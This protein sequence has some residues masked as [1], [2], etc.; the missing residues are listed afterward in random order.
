MAGSPGYMCPEVAVLMLEDKGH[1]AQVIELIVD[2]GVSK[3]TPAVAGAQW[4][5]EAQFKVDVYAFGVLLAALV[6]RGAPYPDALSA[7]ELLYGTAREGLRPTVPELHIGSGRHCNEGYVNGMESCWSQTPMDRP[8]FCEVRVLL[9]KAV[10][11][12]EEMA[13]ACGTVLAV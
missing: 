1:D 6:T 8:T 11:A 3:C 10:I 2:Q 12:S 13:E 5:T 7:K 9:E 4:S